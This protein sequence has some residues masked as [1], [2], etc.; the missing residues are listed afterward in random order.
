MT[1]HNFDPRAASA[2][3][4]TLTVMLEADPG[5]WMNLRERDLAAYN[6]RKAAVAE[7][8]IDAL[9]KHL[10]DIRARV[11]MIDVATPATFFRYT[12]NWNGAPMAWQVFSLFLFKPRKR[13]KGLQNFLMCGQWTGDPGLPCA[14]MGGKEAAKMICRQDGRAFKTSKA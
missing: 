2:G 14:A 6:L 7:Q 11:E 5:Y 12:N 1:I 4:T 8:V 9:D 10:G 13:L 3:K